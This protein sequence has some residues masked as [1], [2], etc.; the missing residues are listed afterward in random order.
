VLG[1]V[2]A[3]AMILAY[4]YFDIQCARDQH[5]DAEAQECFAG[6]GE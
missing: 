3:I 5:W 2:G 6:A 4:G 1:I